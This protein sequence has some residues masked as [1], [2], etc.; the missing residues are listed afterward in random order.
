VDPSVTR[1]A[2]VEDHPLYR[3]G[4][5]QAVVEGEGLALVGAFATVGALEVAEGIAIDVLLLDLHLP[6]CEGVNGVLRLRSRADSILI[7]SAAADR[8]SVVSAIAAGAK[9][10]LSKA[11]DS[12]EI[13]RAIAMVRAGDTYVS[14]QLAAFFLREARNAATTGELALTKRELEILSLLAEGETDADIA[15]Q[16][17][18]SIRTVR[19]HLDRIRDKTGRRR[20][21]DLTRLA[22]EQAA[23]HDPVSRRNAPKS[24]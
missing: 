17:Y 9:G 12:D 5:S 7:V 1:V 13:R 19:S 2:I 8:E 24:D 18:I 10:Y 20:R 15:R 16:L 23:G 21:A 22:L 4:L 6:D 3:Q 14:P 11:S